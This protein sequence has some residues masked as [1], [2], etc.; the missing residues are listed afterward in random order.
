MMRNL[1]HFR[2][3]EL[4]YQTQV[5]KKLRAL[6]QI[7]GNDTYL[8]VSSIINLPAATTYLHEFLYPYQFNEDQINDILQSLGETGKIFY[9][10]KY[11]IVLDR[12]ILFLLL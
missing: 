11:R 10:E 2:E 12:K 7:K 9:S 3:I 6:T 8:P 1:N 5:K 4:I